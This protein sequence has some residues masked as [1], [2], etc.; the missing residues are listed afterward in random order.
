M[1]SMYAGTVEAAKFTR[2]K[3]INIISIIDKMTAAVVQY[4]DLILQTKTENRVFANLLSAVNVLIYSL[5]TEAAL[6]DR[7]KARQALA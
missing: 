6:R 3:N 1:K 4:S 7:K 5:A 2:S